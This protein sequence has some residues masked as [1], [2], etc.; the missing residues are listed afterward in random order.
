MNSKIL[1]PD[2]GTKLQ[3]L[4]DSVRIL[5]QGEQTQGAYEVFELVG[6]RHSGPP[7]HDHPWSES[8]CILEGEVEVLSG[9][10]TVR[11]TPGYFINIPGGTL[12]SYRILSDHARFLVMASTTAA[13]AFFQEIHD[14]M[15]GD[16]ADMDRVLAIAARHGVRVGKPTMAP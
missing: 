6:P 2:Q 12:H 4:Q 7:P 13:S 9:E 14:A 15:V 8:Y 5:T 16:E 11:A 10:Q 1:A 3:I